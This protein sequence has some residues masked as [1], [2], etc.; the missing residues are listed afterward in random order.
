MKYSTEPVFYV[1]IYVDPTTKQP[2][3]VG[4]GKNHRY[5]PKRHLNDVNTFLV[6]VLN[7][8]GVD[9][10]KIAFAKMSLTERDALKLEKTLV[11]K[12]GRRI[13]GTGTLT[14]ITAG[15]RGSY[16]RPFSQKSREKLSKSRTGF[17]HNAKT[18]KRISKT[19]QGWEF[20]K[21]TRKKIA[22]KSLGRVHS[23]ETRDKISKGL[24]KYR[25]TGVAVVKRSS[26]STQRQREYNRLYRKGYRV[27]LN[28]L[29]QILS[30]DQNE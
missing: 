14:N 23:K 30:G 3:Y 9:N 25:K 6:N 21:A 7:K 1:Y 19:M 29:Q 11:E 18:K 4:K 2:F 27:S 22:Q 12:F 15:G 16:G 20:S 5:L 26:T 10:V 28:N 8:I 13:V 24:R 17:H